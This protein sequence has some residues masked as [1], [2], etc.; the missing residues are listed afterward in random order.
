MIADDCSRHKQ[1]PITSNM[2]AKV[3]SVLDFLYISRI[4]ITSNI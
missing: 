1:T 3:M 4:D 2:M